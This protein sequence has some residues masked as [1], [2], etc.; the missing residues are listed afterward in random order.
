VRAN[1]IQTAAAFSTMLSVQV[2]PAG[3]MDCRIV[4]MYC[5]IWI[6]AMQRTSTWWTSLSTLSRWSHTV[7]E[8]RPKFCGASWLQG[9]ASPSSRRT[10]DGPT[11]SQTLTYSAVY[12]LC[13]V[14]NAYR[15]PTSIA[16][17]TVTMLCCLNACMLHDWEE[18]NT[19]GICFSHPNTRGRS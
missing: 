3:S 18:E 2:C 12:L 14:G 13:L 5:R 4:S 15:L 17:D 10:S 8:A 19:E 1:W 16:I 11:Y 9:N 6:L 7:E